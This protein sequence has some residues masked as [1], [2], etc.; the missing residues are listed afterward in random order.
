MRMIIVFGLAFQL[1]LLL[2]MLNFG[3]IVSGEVTLGWWRAMIMSITLFAAIA[4]PSTDPIS[5]LALAGP[6]LGA[7][8]RRHWRCPCSMI[9]AG[10]G[11]RLR[12]LPTTKLLTSTS[13]LRASARSSQ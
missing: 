13:P 9:G 4:T 6:I 11:V 12:A 7:V 5:M 10:R 2:V 1:P 3:G 8:L